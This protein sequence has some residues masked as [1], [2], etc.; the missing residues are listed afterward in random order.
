MLV[1]RGVSSS[2]MLRG[3]VPDIEKRTLYG[4]PLIVSQKTPR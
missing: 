3:R 2:G 1:K 4:C